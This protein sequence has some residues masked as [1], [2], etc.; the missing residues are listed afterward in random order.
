M[1]NERIDLY[2]EGE[3]TYRAAYGFTPNI[4]TYV[5]EGGSNGI[6][7]LVVPGGAYCMVVPQEGE[8]VA[9]RF[10]EMGMNAFVLT[11]TTDITTAVPLMKQPLHDISRAVK[12]ARKYIASKNGSDGK[13]FVCGFSAGGHLCGTLATHWFDVEDNDEKYKDFTNRPDGAILCY[14][15]I[16][17][18]EFTENFSK[19]NLVGPNPTEELTDYFS[20]EKAVTEKTVPCFLWHTVS[21]GLVPVENSY[22]FAD[23]LRK[24]KVPYAQ[25]VFSHGDHGLSV[26]DADFF[27][28]KHGEP[29]TFE[30][31][32]NAVAAVKAGTAVDITERRTEELK[33]QFCDEP[34]ER[35]EYPPV[36]PDEFADVR[37]WLELARK[38]MESIK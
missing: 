13:M 11:Y 4:R 17:L 10:Y 5:H 16:T 31:L 32:N 38:W 8:I 22:L 26:A 7:V 1:I 34:G 27:A 36:N 14:P 35:P 29:Y 9:K 18:G 3:Y 21:D 20:L 6:N 33:I 19:L 37:T 30:Q 15:V 12:V 23:A 28:G 24:N 2:D 25:H